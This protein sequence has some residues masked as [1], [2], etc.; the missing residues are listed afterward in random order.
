MNTQIGKALRKFRKDK[1]MTLQTLSQNTGLS[2]AYLSLVE[3]GINSPT[4]EN[5]NKICRSLEITMVNLLETANDTTPVVV[6]KE[7]RRVIYDDNG[8][9]YEVATEGEHEMSCVVLTV[10]DSDVHESYGHIADEV[11]YVVSGTMLMTVDGIEYKLSP[12]D[13]IY[14][15]ANLSHSY[16]KTSK[17][18]CV[19]V[20]TYA[21][22]TISD[23]L[24]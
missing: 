2:T 7:D 6:K 8:I 23:M 3:R 24:D 20:W 22:P 10:S 12:G 17:E 9:H 16:K 14:I 15:E 11:G 19:T 13:C 4:I 21:N 5:L 18:A 1:Q